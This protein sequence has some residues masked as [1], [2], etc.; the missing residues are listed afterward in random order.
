MVMVATLRP[1]APPHI[2]AN[3]GTG[4]VLALNLQVREHREHA[5]VVE[6][7]QSSCRRF[8]SAT[9]FAPGAAPGGS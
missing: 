4:W 8:A 9:R 6:H 2:G 5:P 1:A 3:T 7:A